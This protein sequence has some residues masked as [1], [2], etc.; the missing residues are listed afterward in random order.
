MFENFFNSLSQTKNLFE[1]TIKLISKNPA[2]WQVSVQS[3]VISL[4]A[5][6]LFIIGLWWTFFPPLAGLNVIGV[7]LL[8]IGAVVSFI[9]LPFLRFY[10]MSA[11]SW[12][13]YQTFT[14]KNVPAGEGFRRANENMGDIAL[15]TLI[16]FFVGALVGQMKQAQSQQKGLLGIIIGFI[17]GILIA[18]IKEG[19]DLI[20]H[21]LVPAS[22]IPEASAI[23]AIKEI[24]KLR[25][26]IP[27]SLV[28]VLGIDFV[29]DVLIGAVNAAF[30]LL[31]VLGIII[32]IV[33]GFW[34]ALILFFILMIMANII[35]GAGVQLVKTVYFTVFYVLLTRKKE[36]SKDYAKEIES[37]LAIP[38][39]IK[40]K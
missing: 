26:N 13:V 11:Q 39:K 35:M 16:D 25:E 34:I 19:W 1:S 29:G 6:L 32:G 27:A 12:I 14:G 22:I 10:F 17:I 38:S 4:V 9:V 15:L 3:F 18:G 23:Q 20:S 40:T 30:M 21:F 33:T 36:I 7:I 37:Y 8:I 5:T 24:P 28:G 2:I 31:I